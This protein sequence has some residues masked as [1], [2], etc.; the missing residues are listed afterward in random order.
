MNHHRRDFDIDLLMNDE[1]GNDTF[2]HSH[3]GHN[4]I[5]AFIDIN[6]HPY[7]LDDYLD[8]IRFKQI[9]VASVS[10]SISISSPETNRTIVEISI[11]NTKPII[12][13]RIKYSR[14]IETIF[15]NVRTDRQNILPVIQKSLI[16]EVSYTLENQ[17]TGEILKSANEKLS[18][19]NRDYFLDINVKSI[20]DNA[21]DN[22]LITHF[23]DSLVTSVMEFLHGSETMIC[24]VN[25]IKLFYP[26]VLHKEHRHHHHKD[27]FRHEEV[28]HF[29]HVSHSFRYNELYHFDN[30]GDRKSVV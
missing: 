23:E 4:A 24:R 16:A 20:A 5:N 6:G 9:D 25:N 21:I 12:G 17:Q 8:D 10:N 11:D 27:R 18:I 15:K 29:E 28:H 2:H 26:A 22:C 13:N 3:H 14:L 19:K 30:N 1:M 7:I